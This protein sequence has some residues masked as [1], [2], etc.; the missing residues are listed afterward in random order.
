MN[1]TIRSLR[2]LAA[3]AAIALG[4]VAPPPA[5][6]EAGKPSALQGIM[7]QLGEDMQQVTHAI[8]MEDWQRV[9]RLAPGIARHAQPP[10]GE[11]LRILGWLGSDAAQFRGFDGAVHE[12]AT[13]LGEAAVRE[14]GE[15]VIASFAELQRNCLAC[16]Q[17]FR[18]TF[19][20]RFHEKS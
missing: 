10:A 13:A 6:A 16:H 11:K 8:S 9:A 18:A 3:L 2:A 14:D 15:A 20:A 17:R 12:T 19:I 7:R 5:A 4:A 1:P